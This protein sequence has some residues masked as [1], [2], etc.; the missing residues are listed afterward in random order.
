MLKIITPT[1]NIEVATYNEGKIYC[2]KEVAT[3]MKNTQI[4]STL[5]CSTETKIL[6][7]GKKWI[8]PKH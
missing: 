7:N 5:E 4:Y 8:I 6:C 1:G 2:L 3:E